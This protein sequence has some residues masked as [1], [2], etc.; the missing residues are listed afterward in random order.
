MIKYALFDW[1]NT[2]RK[3]FTITDWMQYLFE[4]QVVSKEYYS[5]FMYQFELYNNHKIDYKKLSD[6]TTY[7]Y[8]NA[9]TGK[10]VLEMENMAQDFCIKDQAVFSFTDKLFKKFRENNI[11]IIVVSGTPQM[12]LNYYSRLLGIDEAYGLVIGIAADCFVNVIQKDYGAYKEDIVREICVSKGRLP[13]FALGDSIADA[14]LIDK[15]KYGCYINK[16]T[17]AI[18]LGDEKIGYLSSAYETIL[19]LI[20]NDIISCT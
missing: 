19:N 10:N 9:I 15:A 8:A 3:G 20:V 4:K 11:E 17:G 18:T 16:E 13:I 2:L 14:P 1:D 12:L 6:N 5:N 7:I